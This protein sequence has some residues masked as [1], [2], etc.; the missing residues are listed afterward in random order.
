MIIQFLVELFSPS[1]SVALELRCKQVGMKWYVDLICM[2]GVCNQY[3]QLNDS[4]WASPS[5]PEILAISRSSQTIKLQLAW[6]WIPITLLVNRL[7][8]KKTSTKNC[9][10][11]EGENVIESTLDLP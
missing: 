6:G 4:D 10:H 11:S 3:H 7:V 1:Q 5:Q 2:R 9:I 8:G